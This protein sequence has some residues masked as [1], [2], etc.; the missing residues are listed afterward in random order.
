MEQS[1]D[2]AKV[3]EHFK[4]DRE[5]VEAVLFPHVRYRK[6]ALDRVLKG[7][8][9]LTV[10]QLQALANLSGVFIQDL[11]SLDTWKGGKEDNC[12]TFLKGEFKVKLNYNGVF[13]SIYKG[14]TLVHQEINS[15]NKTLQEFLSY[16]TLLTN[17]L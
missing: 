16:I 8:G 13:L 2:L 5:E 12:L 6:Q 7:E 4:L 11:F 1:F 3:I 14:T 17:K 9:Q 10:E 15:S